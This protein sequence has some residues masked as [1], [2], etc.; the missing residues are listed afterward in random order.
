V[1]GSVL[2]SIHAVFHFVL[3][4][5][6]APFDIGFYGVIIPVLVSG[7]FWLFV[8]GS[9]AFL[10]TGLLFDAY[11]LPAASGLSG[12]DEHADDHDEV[13]DDFD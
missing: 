12:D 8:L 4:F 6:G 3:V 7:A 9:G 2:L 1:V 5:L 11:A 13:G 10:I